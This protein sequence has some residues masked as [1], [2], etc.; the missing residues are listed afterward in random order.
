VEEGVGTDDEVER[1]FA[2]GGIE[3]LRRLGDCDGWKRGD[4][5]AWDLG[6]GRGDADEKKREGEASMTG[7]R[8]SGG[9]VV[10]S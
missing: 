1:L 2:D 6:V 3:A 8:S 10:L 4:G 5:L 9:H 7:Q